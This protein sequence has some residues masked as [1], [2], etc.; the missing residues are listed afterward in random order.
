MRTGS[1]APTSS[2]RLTVGLVTALA[3]TV[4]LAPAAAAGEQSYPRPDGSSAAYAFSGRGYGHGHGMSQFGAEGM[5]RSGKTSEEIL[6]FYYPGTTAAAAPRRMRMRV[7][8]SGVVR[9]GDGWRDIR[10]SPAAGLYVRDRTTGARLKLPATLGG[11]TVDRWRVKQNDRGLKL[12]GL[13]GARY[14]GV[15]GWNRLTG[16]LRLAR[17]VPGADLSRG[18]LQVVTPSGS[19]RRYRGYLDAR[20]ESAT[21]LRAVN[22]L[23]LDDYVGSV[24]SAEVPAYWQQ[25]ALRAQAVA[26]RTYALRL[27]HYARAGGRSYDVCD[28]MSCQ[29]YGGVD[30]ESAAP[31]AAAHGTAQRYLAYGG[32]P[33]LT[34]FS[35]AN[36]GWSAAGGYPY[37]VARKDPYDGVVPP[38]SNWGHAWTFSLPVDRI[39][40]TWPRIGR[41]VRLRVLER[42]GDGAWGGRIHRL[43][44]EGRDGAVEVTGPDF[45]FLFGM[46]S[47][48]WKITNSGTTTAP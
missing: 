11:R 35:S 8:L 40:A 30:R 46:K 29:V 23:R 48:W 12:T 38:E 16:P 39:E 1:P 10:V 42:S 24:V 3:V 22:R 18:V 31:V 28:T 13:A 44:V 14:R 37:L 4:P 6:S 41:L 20:A 33:A 43:V 25:A 47:E 7:D 26:A 45:R 15:D 27:R 21:A 5:A 17:H 9:T 2:T 19:E 36:G 32:L 34:Q